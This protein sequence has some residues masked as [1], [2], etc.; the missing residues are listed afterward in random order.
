[1]RKINYRAIY[2]EAANFIQED[3]D[4]YSCIAIRM[5]CPLFDEVEDALTDLYRLVFCDGVVNSNGEWQCI[6]DLDSDAE[7]KRVRVL[8]LCLMAECWGDFV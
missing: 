2:L 3:L 6:I 1:M 8:M 7:R 5:A 4:Y